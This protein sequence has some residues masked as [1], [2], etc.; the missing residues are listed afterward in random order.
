MSIINRVQVIKFKEC[1]ISD[2]EIEFYKNRKNYYESKYKESNKESNKK[3]YSFDSI[4]YASNVVCKKNPTKIPEYDLIL[5]DEFQDFNKLECELI[6]FLWSKSK[7]VIVGDDD[8]SL[9]EFKKANP[10]KI[11]DLYK[12]EKN[13]NF[14]LPECYRC[15]RVV[16]DAANDIIKN[17][18]EK[19]FLK[20]RLDKAY[21]YPE[22]SK[23]EKDEIS[24][25]FDKIEVKNVLN[26]NRFVQ[27]S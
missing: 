21:R 14:T 3:I 16:V 8:Q 26:Y 13:E 5:V 11:R 1:N 24:K 10:D 4:I 19:G 12:D 17:S 20:N 27:V 23:S 18:K 9:Y 25:I 15:T 22:K 7:I 2:A 6:E